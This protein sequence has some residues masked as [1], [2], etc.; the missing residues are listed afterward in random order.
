[1][2]AGQ[3]TLIFQDD[4]GF[5]VEYGHLDS[6]DPAMRLGA[7]VRPGQGAGVVGRKGASGNFSHLHVGTYLTRD[8]LDAGHNNRALNLYPWLVTAYLE[9][10]PSSLYAVARPHH[11]VR[12]GAPVQLDGSRSIATRSKIISHRWQFDDGIVVHGDHAR[13][14]FS[15]PGQYSAAL[16]IE[17]DRGEVDVDFCKIRVF[18]ADVSAPAIPALFVTCFPTRDVAVNGPVRFRI[19]PQGGEVRTVRVDFGDGARIDDYLPDVEVEHAF[20]RE[21]IHVVT[22][23]ASFNGIRVTR[24]IEVI[25]NPADGGTR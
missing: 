22:A 25:V 4:Q 21:G 15:R 14:T 19:W 6:I 24:Q 18:S 12:A 8:D 20:S 23:S 7:R 16:W 17:D 13:R 5:L 11:T 1:V 10:S 2:D 9:R 3:G